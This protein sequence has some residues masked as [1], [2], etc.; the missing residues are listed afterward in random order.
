M[1]KYKALKKGYDG[2]KLREPGEVFEFD[3]KPGSWMQALDGQAAPAP[4]VEKPE[5]K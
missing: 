1:P 2:V 4:A 5:P 3:G